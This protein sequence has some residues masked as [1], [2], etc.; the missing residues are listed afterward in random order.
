[1]KKIELKYPRVSNAKRYFDILNNPGFKY[2]R[3]SINSV[4]DEEKWLKDCPKRRK[5]NY[6]Y[7]YSIFYNNKLVGGIGIKINQ[8]EQY[9]GEIGYFVDKNY[10]NKGIATAAVKKAEKI[11]FNKL[12]LKRIEIRININ[13]KASQKVA[14]KSGYKKEGTLKKA[15]ELKGKYYDAILYA[16]VRK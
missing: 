11:G 4:K 2:F 16:K 3:V 7:D 15:M 10:W 5:N 6:S 12:R 13:N 8:H 1:M 9:I 14:I